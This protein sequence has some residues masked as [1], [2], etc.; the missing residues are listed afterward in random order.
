MLQSYHQLFLALSLAFFTGMACT[1]VPANDRV[2]I[3]V[4]SSMRPVMDDLAEAFESSTGNE[5][6]ISAASTGVLVAQ[7]RQGAPF[8]VLLSADMSFPLALHQEGW[9]SS[10]PLQYAVGRLVLLSSKEG[11]MLQSFSDLS[12]PSITKIA[13]ADTAVAPFG[14]AAYQ[15][16]QQLPGFQEHIAP[17]L[18]FGENVG[19]VLQ[20]LHAGA[21]DGGFVSQ[22]MREIGEEHQLPVIE[23]SNQ[24]PHGI[25]QGLLLLKHG[26]SHHPVAASAFVN[27]MRS[28]Q[29]QSIL[30]GYGYSVPSIAFK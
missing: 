28:Q 24:N 26:E 27:F 18:V 7:I 1:S 10:P 6:E 3:A 30:E 21:V 14:A 4:T 15:L 11:S 23:L 8:D 2:T 16:L 12:D 25:P 29:A 22:S 17:K 13:I 5:V 9:S 20:Y 19:Q